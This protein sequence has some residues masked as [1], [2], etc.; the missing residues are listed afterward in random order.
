LNCRHIAMVA[1]GTAVIPVIQMIRAIRWDEWDAPPTWDSYTTPTAQRRIF[2]CARCPMYA[3][4]KRWLDKPCA[5]YVLT[6][7]SKG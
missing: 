3:E 5:C 6:E 1:G 7:R 4:A 2:C